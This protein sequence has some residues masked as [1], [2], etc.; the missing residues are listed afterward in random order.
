MSEAT[1]DEAMATFAALLKRKRTLDNEQELVNLDLAHAAHVVVP[2]LVA[3][4]NKARELAER[5][6]ADERERCAKVVELYLIDSGIDDDAA[7]TIGS[8]DKH[9]AEI[10]RRG[11]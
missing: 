1:L 8:R 4:L 2:K 9:I 5:A 10:I 11:P 6:S 7:A 3:E